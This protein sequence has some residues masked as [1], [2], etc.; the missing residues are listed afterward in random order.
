VNQT[1]I[2]QA[3]ESDIQSISRL[4]QQWF[5]EGGIHG[6]VPE[7]QEQIKVA[8]SPYL[9]VALTNNEVIGFISG[10]IRSSEGKL[11]MRY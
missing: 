5:E 7:S 6:F 10:S 2:R 3:A 9:L 1:F 8:L 11:R 4:Q